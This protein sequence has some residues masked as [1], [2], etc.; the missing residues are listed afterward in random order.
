MVTDNNPLTYVFTTAKLDA[1]EQRWLAELSNYNCSLTYRSGRQNG[2]ADGLSRIQEESTTTTTTVFPG[3]MKAIC[4][5]MSV[6]EDYQPCI[7]ML[8]DTDKEEIPDTDEADLLT[9]EQLQA[10]ALSSHD[11]IGAQTKDICLKFVI[12]CLLEGRKTN[13]G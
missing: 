10:T 8:V 9:E 3:V 5:S 2:D 12:D 1:T 6:D 11:W 4:H 13:S 7:N